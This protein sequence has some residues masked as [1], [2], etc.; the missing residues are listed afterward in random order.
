M[1][2][3]P[4]LIEG[5]PKWFNG[6]CKNLPGMVSGKIWK[7]REGRQLFWRET[8]EPSNE[9]MVSAKAFQGWLVVR[10][11][12]RKREEAVILKRRGF[13]IY[14]AVLVIVVIL[15]KCVFMLAVVPTESMAGTIEPGN[16]VICSR[17]GIGEGDIERYDVLVFTPP[18]HPQMLYIKRVV[19]LPGETI[20]IKNGKVYA[21]GVE[22]DSSF[23]KAPQNRRGDGIYKVP[24]GCYFF[25]GDNRNNS[26]DSRF[27]KQKYVPAANLKAK[28]RLIAFPFTRIGWL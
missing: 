7:R 20:E 13:I 23:T 8:G 6:L 15:F 25:L 11:G 22:L 5:T 16:H 1:G 9:W 2:N 28:A 24:D 10:Y 17:Y 12:K 19:G 18:D 21:D 4:I 27:W 14:V 26:N 3:L